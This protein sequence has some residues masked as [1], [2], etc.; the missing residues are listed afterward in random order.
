MQ[1]YSTFFRKET[2][3]LFQ[4]SVAGKLDV[5]AHTCYSRIWGEDIKG[6]GGKWTTSFIYL[7]SSRPAWE[8]YMK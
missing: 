8:A 7:P 6:S 5:V 2:I 3:I 1:I 4:N